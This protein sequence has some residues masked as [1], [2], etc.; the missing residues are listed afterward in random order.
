MA[1]TTINNSFCFVICID[2]LYKREH[3]RVYGLSPHKYITLVPHDILHN[4]ASR[5]KHF[6]TTTNEVTILE[7]AGDQS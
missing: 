2:P 1:T 7:E 4:S 6:L 5:D 3:H